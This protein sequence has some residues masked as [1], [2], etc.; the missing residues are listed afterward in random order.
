VKFSLSLLTLAAVVLTLPACTTLV[1]RRDLYSPAE[2]S[3]HWSKQYAT[4]HEE[5]EGIFGLSHDVSNPV[6]EDEGIFGVSHSDNRLKPSPGP[7]EGIFGVSRNE[8]R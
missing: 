3:G 5:H 6:R 8:G 4:Y 1:N 2:G 7:E